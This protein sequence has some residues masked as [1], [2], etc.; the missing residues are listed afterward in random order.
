MFKTKVKTNIDPLRLSGI[1]VIVFYAVKS[2]VSHEHRIRLRY[3]PR[4]GVLVFEV[5]KH[6]SGDS[7]IDR[8]GTR[9]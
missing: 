3:M 5:E 8:C 4:L 6:V 7:L 1:G 9:A 2:I